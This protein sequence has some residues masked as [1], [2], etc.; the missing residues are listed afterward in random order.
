MQTIPQIVQYPNDFISA[1]VLK[2]FAL[3]AL[4]KNLTFLLML[5]FLLMCLL[6]WLVVNVAVGHWMSSCFFLM[7]LCVV[8]C[9]CC[10]NLFICRRLISLIF[11]GVNVSWR[12]QANK[13]TVEH[14]G[15]LWIFFS[16]LLNV[17]FPHFLLNNRVTSLT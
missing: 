5:L 15:F 8:A 3:V 13:Q 4:V 6:H 7:L 10:S 11:V 2:F 14:E 12:Q 9:H 16:F 1:F 17:D